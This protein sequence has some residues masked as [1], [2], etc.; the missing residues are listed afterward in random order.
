MVDKARE[1]LG[2]LGPGSTYWVRLGF[3]I[4]VHI[5]L[6]KNLFSITSFYGLIKI[7]I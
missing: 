7:P 3:T 5:F 1:G 6:K 2:H 4:M